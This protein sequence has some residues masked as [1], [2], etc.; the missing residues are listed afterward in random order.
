M[1]RKHWKQPPGA[2]GHGPTYEVA[3][4]KVKGKPVYEM[5]VTLPKLF[6]VSTLRKWSLKKLLMYRRYLNVWLGH[7]CRTKLWRFSHVL[8]GKV[9]DKRE[10]V[11]DLINS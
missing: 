2:F 7:Y 1:P 11:H 5:M 8:Y 3:F 9:S 10:Q 4:H 6:P